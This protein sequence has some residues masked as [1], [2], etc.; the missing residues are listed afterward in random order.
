MLF[1]I[2]TKSNV[3]IHFIQNVKAL[4]LYKIFN[5]WQKS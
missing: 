2:N 3:T 1:I 5:K 4:P